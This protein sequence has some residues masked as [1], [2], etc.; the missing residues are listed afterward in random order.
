MISD[1][2]I[3]ACAA[4]ILRSHGEAAAFHAVQPADEWIAASDIEGQRTW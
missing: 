1:R 2:E 3:W 4:T